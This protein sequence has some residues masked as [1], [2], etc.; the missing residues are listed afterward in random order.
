M[1]ATEQPLYST[2]NERH[3]LVAK[4]GVLEEGLDAAQVVLVQCGV[5]VQLRHAHLGVE[6]RVG[7]CAWVWVGLG[8]ELGVEQ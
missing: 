6:G 5:L 2:D 7:E 3:Y 8:L 4:A 1:L